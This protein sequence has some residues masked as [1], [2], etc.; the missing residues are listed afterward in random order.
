LALEQSRVVEETLEELGAADKPVVVAL[1][2]IDLLPDPER[3]Q[4]MLKGFR[5]S[6]AIS[7][8]EGIGLRELLSRISSILGDR[9]PLDHRGE[10]RYH[11]PS[12]L[13]TV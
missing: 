5:N 13:T 10:E 2:K 9:F 12:S 6:L 1:N 8:K 3:I 7:A 11:L 4:E